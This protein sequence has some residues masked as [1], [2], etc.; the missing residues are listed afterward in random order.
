V[1]VSRRWSPRWQRHPTASHAEL[2]RRRTRLPIATTAR[3]YTELNNPAGPV[4]LPLRPVDSTQDR[5][6]VAQ[7]PAA[8]EPDGQPSVLANLAYQRQAEA[9]AEIER[10][11]QQRR[12]LHRGWQGAYYSDQS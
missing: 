5:R 12:E 8:T 9:R 2:A 6:S 3:D 11:E 10:Q 4:W 1:I 7:L